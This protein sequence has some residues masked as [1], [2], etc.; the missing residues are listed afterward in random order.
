MTIDDLIQFAVSNNASDLHISGQESPV[1]RVHGRLKNID[2]PPLTEE[3]VTTMID[4]TLNDESKK[5]YKENWDIDYCYDVEGVARC[6]ANAYLGTRGACASFRIIRPNVLPWE[7]FGLP[8]NVKDLA[9]KEKGLILFTGPAGCGKSTT[10]TSFVDIINNTRSAHILTL[11]DPIE[12]A[13]TPKQCLISQRQIGENTKSFAKALEAAMRE[14]PDIIVVGE[15]RDRE[16]IQL[17]L[18]A[19]ETGHLVIS[20]LH[21][22]SAPKTISR[23]INTFPS[24]EQGQIRTMLG[25]GLLAVVSQ[26]LVPSKDKQSV[27]PAFE[28]LLGTSSV[29]SMIRG[30][31]IHELSSAIET[32]VKYNMCTMFHSL[33]Q[34]I[35]N[36]TCLREDCMK[37]V[38][39]PDN[40]PQG[41]EEPQYGTYQ[42]QYLHREQRQATQEA[43][44]STQNNQE[45]LDAIHEIE[46]VDIP[47]DP[48]NVSNDPVPV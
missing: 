33:E 11:E 13:H 16:T 22:N 18:T 10:M 4:A 20:T 9:K 7:S 43:A 21:T 45:V 26:A 32:G 1:I 14:D 44:D 2:T 3:Q 30:N 41:Q 27:V 24:S 40:L 29:K 12:F 25:E 34:L 31:K 19:A 46:D 39:N 15:M 28:I 38:D 42:P 8:D 5:L 47:N 6:R 37:F 36:G 17:A 48:E 23:I 35:I